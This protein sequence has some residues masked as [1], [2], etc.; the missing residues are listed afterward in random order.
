MDSYA[1]AQ[2]EGY[3]SMYTILWW[4]WTWFICNTVDTHITNQPRETVPNKPA[5]KTFIRY[6]AWQ[7]TETIENTFND[8]PQHVRTHM[9]T[10]LTRSFRSPFP[11]INIQRHHE[12]VA[13]GIIYAATP[14]VDCGYTRAQF[15]CWIDSQVCDVYGIKTDK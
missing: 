7:P 13:T 4:P 9:S 12:Y 14:A 11:E 1:Y 10:H 6:F 15:Y 8:T 2:I 5:Y 3:S